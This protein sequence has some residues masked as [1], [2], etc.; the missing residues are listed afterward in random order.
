M[1]L[2]NLGTI[3]IV[4]ESIHNEIRW[5]LYIDDSKYAC[6]SKSTNSKNGMVQF[7]WQIYGPQYWLKAKVLMQG[8]L[9]LSIIADQLS[10]SK[11]DD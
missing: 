9:E 10:E 6:V 1:T 8:L 2:S 11:N 5:Q 4:D 7:H 3:K